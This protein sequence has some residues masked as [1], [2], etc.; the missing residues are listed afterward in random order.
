[1]VRAGKQDRGDPF[2]RGVGW[3][4]A[5]HRPNLP[6]STENMNYNVVNGV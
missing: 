6:E 5:A 1:M 4:C 3:G 2:L